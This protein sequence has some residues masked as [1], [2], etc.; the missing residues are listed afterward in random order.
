MTK[1]GRLVRYY[2]R[3]FDG[4]RDCA[5]GYVYDLE[6]SGI[7]LRLMRKFGR[8]ALTGYKSS[9]PVKGNAVLAWFAG[10]ERAQKMAAADPYKA[11]ADV[12]LKQMDGDT[13]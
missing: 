4:D 13:V 11:V 7:P 8:G 3:Q 5:I 1:R 10:Q 12:L 9:K 6:Q 2:T